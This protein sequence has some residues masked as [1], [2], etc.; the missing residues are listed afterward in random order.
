MT[1]GERE[2]GRR[3]AGGELSDSVTLFLLDP[4]LVGSSEEYYVEQP[5]S[6]LSTTVFYNVLVINT[7]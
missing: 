4:S 2:K 1:L 5:D 7:L 6:V 3:D